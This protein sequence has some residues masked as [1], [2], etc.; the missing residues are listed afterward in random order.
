MKN[1]FIILLAALAGALLF[2]SIS[3]SSAPT[4]SWRLAYSHDAGGKAIEGSKQALID[5]IANGKPVR[6]YWAGRRVQHV[7]DA[8]FLTILQGEVFAQMH[9]I[10]GQKPSV[11][12]AAVELR[13]ET[14]WQTIHATNGTRALKWFVQD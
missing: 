5:A 12:P 1:A 14:S 3:N 9:P 10:T 2:S 11:D 6:V 8:G 4:G 7:V 13:E